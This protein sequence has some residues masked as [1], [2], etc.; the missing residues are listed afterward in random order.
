LPESP[1]AR[2]SFFQ[3]RSIVPFI[4]NVYQTIYQSQSE[5]LTYLKVTEEKA[6]EKDA[7]SDVYDPDVDLISEMKTYSL[8]EVLTPDMELGS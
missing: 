1:S 6:Q 8:I 3:E 7:K 4:P 5:P 2:Q